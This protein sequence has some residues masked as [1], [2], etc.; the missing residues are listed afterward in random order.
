MCQLAADTWGIVANY[1][2]GFSPSDV[3]SWWVTVGCDSHPRSD[4]LRELQ[5]GP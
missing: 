4:T 5:N 2:W 1:T 3:Q